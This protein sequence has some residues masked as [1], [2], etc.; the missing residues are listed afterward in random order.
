V[1]PT[2]FQ[3]EI[4]NAMHFVPSSEKPVTDNQKP[5]IFAL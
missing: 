5:F 1:L 2:I 3:A 4:H